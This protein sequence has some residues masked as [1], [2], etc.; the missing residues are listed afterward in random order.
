MSTKLTNYNDLSLSNVNLNKHYLLN[1]LLNIDSI[2]KWI[3][4]LWISLLN[5]LWIDKYQIKMKITF[6]LTFLLLSIGKKLIL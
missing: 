1:I 3:F 5:I 6:M 2:Y 4:K